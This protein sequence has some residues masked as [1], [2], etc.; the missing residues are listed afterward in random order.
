MKLKDIAQYLVFVAQYSVV[1][2]VATAIYFR[3]YQRKEL[4]ILLFGLIATLVLDIVFG[5]FLLSIKYST[6]YFFTAIDAIT[7][8]SMFAAALPK[9]RR[10]QII[11]AV[12]FIMLP[13]IAF[14]AFYWSG[15]NE[16]GVSSTLVTLLIASISIYYLSRLFK[17]TSIPSLSA[18]PLFWVCLGLIVNNA[19]GFFDVFSKPIL[20]YSQ[21][22]YL[23]FYMVWSIATIFMY[24][25]FAYAFWL[26]KRPSEG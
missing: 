26:A 23:Q 4:K 12:G 24:C 21:N 6:L 11:Q 18:E 25:C 8:T 13:L 19:V 7:M 15:V 10:S 16:N 9:G 5:L 14:D 3:A 17:D 2:P 1:L 20:T 22:M